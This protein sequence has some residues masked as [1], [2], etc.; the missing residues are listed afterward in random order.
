[1]SK[2]VIR[3]Q[4]TNTIV[5]TIDVSNKNESEIEK[6]ERGLLRQMDSD[7]FMFGVEE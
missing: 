3:E 4:D 1:M 7:R 5:H 2:I 6:I